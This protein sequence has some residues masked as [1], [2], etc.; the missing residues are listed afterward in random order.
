MLSRYFTAS[1]LSAG[2]F[3]LGCSASR[4]VE[5]TG[6]VSAASAQGEIV[7][8]FFDVN[9]NEKTSV[10][11][12]KAEADGSFKATVSVEGD[13]LLVRA[14]ADADADGACSDGEQ[15]GEATAKIE[16]DKVEPITIALSS[17]AC[18]SE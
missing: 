6:Q 2:L 13:E 15:W 18:P 4:D 1:I 12:A 7:L 17:A 5:V 11:T 9:G 14:L 3:A 8:E 16:D 10:H